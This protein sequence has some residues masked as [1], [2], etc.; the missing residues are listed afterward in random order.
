MSKFQF[1]NE[2]EPSQQIYE[3]VQRRRMVPINQRSMAAPTLGTKETSTLSSLQ[4]ENDYD[5]A[6]DAFGEFESA[7]HPDEDSWV[8]I[9]FP[10]P[11]DCDFVESPTPSPVPRGYLRSTQKIDHFYQPLDLCPDYS[12]LDGLLTLK[13]SKLPSSK[14]PTFDGSD[15]DDD[16]FEII[17]HSN[18][19]EPSP[20]Q[21]TRSR[22][23]AT[24]KQAFAKFGI[25][26]KAKEVTTGWA[27]GL[28]NH[29][30]EFEEVV[31]KARRTP[32]VV[33][34]GPPRPRNRSASLRIQMEREER[35]EK[36]L[37]SVKL[38]HLPPKPS[39]SR[40]R[41]VPHRVQAQVAREE[42]KGNGSESPKL[43]QLPPGWIEA[44]REAWGQ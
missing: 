37:E 31:A 28:L 34:T 33:E 9:D 35:G 32:M 40:Y 18:T 23:W 11:K 8:S 13:S 42:R 26:E 14:T 17:S 27:A 43:V 15:I 36:G 25:S 39:M 5:F 10:P 24:G 6:D 12:D 30:R 22:M 3:A 38:M 44:E 21:S 7:R 19:R 41:G 16:E 29:E 20:K 1:N 4:P 2:A